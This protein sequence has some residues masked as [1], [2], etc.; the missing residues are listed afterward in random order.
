M[1]PFEKFSSLVSSDQFSEAL[2]FANSLLLNQPQQ[3][4]DWLGLSAVAKFHL[5]DIACLKDF[6]ETILLEPNNAY[7]YSS[8]AYALDALGD[9]AAAIE[10]YLKAVELDP[11]DYIAFNN[12]GL[13][14]EKMGRKS[15]AKKSFD[16]SDEL[17]GL[18][19]KMERKF[20]DTNLQSQINKEK[21]ES[22]WT[23]MKSMLSSKTSW[24]EFLHF[25]GQKLFKS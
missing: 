12:L 6:D 17:M 15:N 21:A 2:N 19:K 22:K 8:R 1:S 25:M 5:K 3:R 24:K 14:Q 23:F 11:E 10:D 7:R 16:A 13:L 4:A 18:S 9:T 20:P